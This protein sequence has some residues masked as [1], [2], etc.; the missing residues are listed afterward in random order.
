[1]ASSTGSRILPLGNFFLGHRQTAL[2]ALEIMTTIR[3]PI[4]PPGTGAAYR[5]FGLRQAANIAVASVAVMIRLADRV[6]VDACLVMG[7]V[8]PT[9]KEVSAINRLVLGMPVSD[10]LENDSLLGEI[11][12]AAAAAAEPIDDIRGSAEFRR[13]ITA[14][15]AKKAFSAALRR[16]AKQP[17]AT[18]K[19]KE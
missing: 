16:A 9:P 7:A 14:V 6:C 18:S 11:G 13:E 1:M 5:K 15:L 19:D 3:V 8:A 4:P 2:E 12:T 10:L 17:E